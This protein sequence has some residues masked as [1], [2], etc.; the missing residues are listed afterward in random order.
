M[1]QRPNKTL[2]WQDL[3]EVPVARRR[4]ALTRFL[5]R[6]F[7]L[8]NA[9]VAVNG[10]LRRRFYVR[11]LKMW[12]Y[13]RGLAALPPRANGPVLDFGGGGTLPPF[14]IAAQGIP[15]HVLDINQALTQY[16]ADVAGRRGWPI[17]TDVFDL[18]AEDAV[19]PAEWRQKFDRVYSYCVMEHIPMAGQE[20]VLKLLAQ[21][22]RPG[23]GMVVTFEFGEHAPAEQP[24]H[25]M[26]RVDKMIAILKG[27]GMRLQGEMPFEDS[28][29]RFALDQAFPNAQ[30]T[31]GMLVV[32][33]PESSA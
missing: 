7:V 2:D 29:G 28:G 9:V 5:W 15:V 8:R 32:E 3:Q 14:F 19:L 11:R 27:Q 20:R 22:V 23:G 18:A 24:W 26:E 13:A 16:S 17:T 30:F 12:E 33:K 1:P 21:A 10:I 25:T 31:F 4:R 6:Q